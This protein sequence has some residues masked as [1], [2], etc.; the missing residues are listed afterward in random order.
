MFSHGMPQGT[1]S[2]R[3]VQERGVA[4]RTSE[5]VPP[6]FRRLFRQD[7]LA[8]AGGQ[9]PEAADVSGLCGPFLAFP[10]RGTHSGPVASPR[11]VLPIERRVRDSVPRPL[12]DAFRLP[13]V[14]TSV[15]E[16]RQRVYAQLRVWGVS[17]ESCGDAQL[18][19]SELFTNAVRH[20]DSEK[21]SCELWVIGVR[22]RLEVTD[23][24]GAHW[25]HPPVVREVVDTS[26]ESGRGLLLV[27][28]L[29]DEWGIRPDEQEH[30]HAVWAELPCVRTPA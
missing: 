3:T 6:T 5:S 27:N 24:G 30:G 1:A 16:A 18:L 4:S 10:T 7:I 21:V 17:E 15:A 14:D 19:V 29:A 2:H 22:L 11:E 25:L 26:G 9:I 13:A 23:E 12:R 28:A 20:T 8:C